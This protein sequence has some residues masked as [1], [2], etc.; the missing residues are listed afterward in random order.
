MESN[1]KQDVIFEQ[2]TTKAR[3]GE[4]ASR[5]CT[6]LNLTMPCVIDG[7]DNAV[8]EAYAAWPERLFVVSVDGRIAYAGGQGPYGFDPKALERWLRRNL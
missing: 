4:I 6:T 1:E 7:M 2:P 8:D 5:C 3:R